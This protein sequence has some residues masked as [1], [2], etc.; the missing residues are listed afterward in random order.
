MQRARALLA[1]RAR[2][3]A[4]SKCARLGHC[5]VRDQISDKPAAPQS[6]ADRLAAIRQVEKEQVAQE[7]ECLHDKEL[8]QERDAKVQRERASGHEL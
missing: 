6:L 5:A 3:E 8:E 1:G 4:P 2:V 7:V